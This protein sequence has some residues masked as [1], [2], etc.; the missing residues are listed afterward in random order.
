MYRVERGN[1]YTRHEDGSPACLAIGGEGLTLRQAMVEQTARNLARPEGSPSWSVVDE[2][3]PSRDIS[4]EI[5][6]EDIEP[7]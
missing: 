2:L 5:D 6:A 7:A 4:W 3:Q 1:P